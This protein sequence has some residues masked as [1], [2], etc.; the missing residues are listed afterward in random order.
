MWIVILVIIGIV[1]GLGLKIHSLDFMN[2]LAV[3]IVL[4]YL[5]LGW[6]FLCACLVVFS[7]QELYESGYDGTRE[8]RL[9]QAEQSL[10]EGRIDQ[11]MA[12][13]LY[14]KSFEEEFDYAWERGTMYQLYDRYLLFSRAAE[15]DCAYAEEAQSYRERLLQVCADSECPE[16]AL[17]VEYYLRELEKE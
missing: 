9:R 6:V 2:K 11:A 14:D 4:V 7:A 5:V 15:T 17:Y 16:N 10:A 3:K 13:M 1:A 8:E 12:D